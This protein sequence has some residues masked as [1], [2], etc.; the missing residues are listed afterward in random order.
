EAITIN[1][2]QNG[3]KID[4]V[5]V[6]AE[7]GWTYS[8][9]ALDQFDGNGDAYEYEI[10]EIAV[11]GYETSYDVYNVTNTKLCEKFTVE[12]EDEEGKPVTEKEYTFESEDG[13]KITKKTDKNG[14]VTF[15]R[16]E[17][18]EGKYTVK[19][20]DG[21][22]VGEIDVEYNVDCEDNVTKVI[23]PVEKP[24]DPKTCEEVEIT[25]TEDGKPSKN[26]TY[27]L[28][29]KDGKTK[30]TITTDKDGKVTIDRD[31]LPN[32]KYTVTDKDG[33]VVGEVEVTDSCY[34]ELDIKSTSTIGSI[35]PKTATQIFSYI[36]LG[37]GLIGLG[38]AVKFTRR[39]KNA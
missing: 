13:K 19:D 30:V 6:T 16:E 28:T 17:L 15:E 21:N 20:K 23:V 24:E 3:E 36:A 39:R 34:V 18:P 29:S 4:S 27:T 1:L 38:F 9:T 11:D 33:N 14:K 22:K 2:L 5:D 31:K 10:E 7:D 35:L 8:F 32:G 25:I 26:K 12:V 37:L